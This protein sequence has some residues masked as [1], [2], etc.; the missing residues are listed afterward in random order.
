[1]KY[2]FELVLLGREETVL[3]SVFGRLLE[4][5][6]PCGMEMN[7]GKSK[8]MRTSRQTSAIQIIKDQKE[9]KN[10][11]YIKLLGS[12]IKCNARCTHDIQSRITMEIQKYL[13]SFEVW[14]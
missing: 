6:R 3:Q 11:E 13:Q 12:M 10:V 14:C 7:V 2:T 5:G 8:V 9:S 4:I 1:V